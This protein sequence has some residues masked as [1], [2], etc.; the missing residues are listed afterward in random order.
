[1]AFSV[2]PTIGALH[3]Y[4][5]P[6]AGTAEY[7]SKY[8]RVLDQAVMVVHER[9]V[10]VTFPWVEPFWHGVQRPHNSLWLTGGTQKVI[11]VDQFPGGI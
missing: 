2:A 1:M 9:D 6:K 5:S 3:S 8:A 4:E 7:F 10:F 11:D